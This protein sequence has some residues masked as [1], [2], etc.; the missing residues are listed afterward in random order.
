[1]PTAST[2]CRKDRTTTRHR[3]E[4]H[5]T[6]HALKKK[7]KRN[8]RLEKL[9]LSRKDKVSSQLLP[10]S[11]GAAN[12]L[13]SAANL[14]LV[15]ADALLLFVEDDRT[16]NLGSSALTILDIVPIKFGLG[17]GVPVGGA[18]PA[19]LVVHPRASLVSSASLVPRG[20]VLENYS[21]G[22]RLMCRVQ[23]CFFWCVL[24]CCGVQKKKKK[25]RRPPPIA[26]PSS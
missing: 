22:G 18:A 2:W 10:R 1:M 12:Q 21:R 17:Q 16:A 8:G 20:E 4:S 6:I 23:K 15:G 3:S 26:F 25:K 19:F 7:E 11:D 24:V 14:L 13:L 9:Q 5:L